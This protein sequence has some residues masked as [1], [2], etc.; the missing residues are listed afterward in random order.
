M[1]IASTPRDTAYPHSFHYEI[2]NRGS[3]F[4]C[5]VGK[6]PLLPVHVYAVIQYLQAR[7]GEYR[8]SMTQRGLNCDMNNGYWPLPEIRNRIM[9]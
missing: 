4:V 1:P 3:F 6:K 5:R 2:Y 8:T 7:L 9:A